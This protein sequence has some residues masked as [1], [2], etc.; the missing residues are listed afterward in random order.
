[1][2]ETIHLKNDLVAERRRIAVVEALVRSDQRIEATTVLG[3]NR[4]RIWTMV[5]AYDSA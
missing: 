3:S 1:M 2:Y 5:V 4:A